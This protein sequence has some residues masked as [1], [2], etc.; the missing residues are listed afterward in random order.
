MTASA[1]D[2]VRLLG[3]A[4][5]GGDDRRGDIV[6]A[7]YELLD[8]AGLEGFTIRA[9][10]ARTGLARRA[11]YEC[12]SGKD[13]LVLAVF[14]STLLGAA[15]YYQALAARLNDPLETIREIAQGI[16]LT[17]YGFEEDLGESMDRLSA[18][19]AREHLRL[20]ETRPGEL[21]EALRPLLDLIAGQ[22]REGIHTGQLRDADPDLQ[23]RLIYNI[24]ATTAHSELIAGDMTGSDM[25]RRR[26][27]AENLWEFCRRA[28]VA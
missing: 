23:A 12:F 1:H 17:R 22:V 5:G 10:L 9:V 27:L 2:P 6:R 26:A 3:L 7:A 21:Q 25:A 15:E 18:A 4:D 8:E 28:I 19:M 24:V 16:V 11:F 20:A 13:D 14:E